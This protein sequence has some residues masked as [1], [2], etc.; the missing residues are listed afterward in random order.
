MVTWEAVGQTSQ[1]LENW[2]K[3][4]LRQEGREPDHPT[5]DSGVGNQTGELGRYFDELGLM[6]DSIHESSS[7]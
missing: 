2:T 3:L 1:I 5:A 7:A 6:P 4:F